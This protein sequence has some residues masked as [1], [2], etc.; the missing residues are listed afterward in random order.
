MRTHRKREKQGTLLVSVVRRLTSSEP[1]ILS[2]RLALAMAG[3]WAETWWDAKDPAGQQPRNEGAERG[4]RMR[5]LCNP[6]GVFPV[7]NVSLSPFCRCFA[8]VRPHLSLVC[9]HPLNS[10]YDNAR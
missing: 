3:L 2:E 4:K 5:R 10:C 6:S 1:P 8:L 7:D 9:P